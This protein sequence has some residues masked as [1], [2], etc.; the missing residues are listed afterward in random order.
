MNCP[1]CGNEE[2]RVLETRTDSDVAGVRRRRRC[3]SCSGSFYTVEHIDTSPLIV[4]SRHGVREDFDR[5]RLVDSLAVAGAASLP[6]PRREAIAEVV[7]ARLRRT[8]PVVTSQ[9]IGM[10]VLEHLRDVHLPTFVRYSLTFLR[11]PDLAAFERWLAR[12]AETGP[13]VGSGS[14]DVIVVKSDGSRE[15]YEERRVL[16]SLRHASR[17]REAITADQIDADALRITSEVV[18]ES[19]TR[20]GHEIES[21]RIAEIILDHLRQLDPL[22]YL[23]YA[24]TVKNLDTYSRLW[25]QL[26]ALRDSDS[27]KR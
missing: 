23:H 18:R 5:K 25:A 19:E 13:L 17:G 20:G 26:S 1:Y 12:E 8:G 11:P 3:A 14:A 24:V 10:A 6:E 22:A 2:T 16:A 27:V 15:L 7:I 9:E 21:S 4:V